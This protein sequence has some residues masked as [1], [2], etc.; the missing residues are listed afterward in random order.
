MSLISIASISFAAEKYTVSSSITKEPAGTIR[1]ATTSTP[2]F[3]VPDRERLKHALMTCAL[4]TGGFGVPNCMNSV[5]IVT[6]TS[7]GSTTGSIAAQVAKSRI[8][9]KYID[10][11]GGKHITKFEN[12]RVV[13]KYEAPRKPE[14]HTKH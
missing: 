13:E 14:R 9:H 10:S 2:S 8:D 7:G 6:G 12:G 1:S 3:T 5:S 11:Q 4:A